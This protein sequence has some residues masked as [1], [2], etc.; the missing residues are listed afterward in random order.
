MFCLDAVVVCRC[1]SFL[2]WDVST[3]FMRIYVFVYMWGKGYVFSYFVLIQYVF[4]WL[5]G[6]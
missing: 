1:V 2:V 6:I 4:C 3:F 5:G